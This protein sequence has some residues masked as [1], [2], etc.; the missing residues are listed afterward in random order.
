[1]C[2]E[3]VQLLKTKFIWYLY[4]RAVI[5]TSNEYLLDFLLRREFREFVAVMFLKSM[6]LDAKLHISVMGWYDKY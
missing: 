1:M 6:H 4:D 3:I 2:L 5:M